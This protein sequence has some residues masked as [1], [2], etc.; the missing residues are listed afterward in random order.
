MWWPLRTADMA[1]LPAKVNDSGAAL[2]FRRNCTPI[3]PACLTPR[4]RVLSP[5]WRMPLCGSRVPRLVG[6]GCSSAVERPTVIGRSWVRIPPATP[7]ATSSVVE[8]RTVNPGVLGSTPNSPPFPKETRTRGAGS[9]PRLRASDDEASC[10]PA[11]T[12]APQCWT[13]RL[14]RDGFTHPDAT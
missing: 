2:D 13:P 11:D 14:R 1:E 9:F 6:R 8:H 3:E 5:G 12:A 7:N 10:S 4:V